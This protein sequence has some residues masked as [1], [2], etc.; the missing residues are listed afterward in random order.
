MAV[1]VVYRPLDSTV[2]CVRY[3]LRF[4]EECI[5]QI[6]DDSF[7]IQVLGD[8]NFP[9]VDYESL[10]VHSHESRDSALK[11]FHFIKSEEN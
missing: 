1:A 4:L 7:Q 2:N 11:L 6:D 3:V 8:F 10:I 5:T 9:A